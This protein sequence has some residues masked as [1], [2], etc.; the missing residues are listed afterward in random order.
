[1]KLKSSIVAKGNKQAVGGNWSTFDYCNKFLQ[2]SSQL[3]AASRML[4]TNMRDLHNVRVL[5]VRFCPT[6]HTSSGL[7]PSSAV[8]AVKSGLSSVPGISTGVIL[9]ALRSRPPEESL[10][11]VRLSH[12][13]G[14][15]FDVAGDEGS[16]PI[17]P[18]LPS[19]KLANQLD[20]KVTVHAGEWPVNFPYPPGVCTSRDN[21][22]VLLS[23]GVS[24]SRLGHGTFMS[25]SQRS[26]LAKTKVTV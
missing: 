16:Y 24:L 19:L 11:I 8:L 2:T 26:A 3:S 17:S 20:V 15:G 12:S 5:E 10:D 18:F 6:L 22:S 9:C 13:H 23:S 21:L 7:T 25:A 1:M 4:A 14:C